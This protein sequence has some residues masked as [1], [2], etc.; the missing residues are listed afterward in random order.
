MIEPGKLNGYP[1]HHEDARPLYLKI[2]QD[3]YDRLVKAELELKNLQKK[4]FDFAGRVIDHESDTRQST[5]RWHVVATEGNPPKWG[6]YVTLRKYPYGMAV[7][8]HSYSGKK[9]HNWVN[10]VAWISKQEMLEAGIDTLNG[11]KND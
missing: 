5:I 3:E 6:R 8:E 10:V 11:L 2:P 1:L 9:W 7:E 4:V